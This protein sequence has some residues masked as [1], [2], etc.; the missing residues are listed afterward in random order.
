[1]SVKPITIKGDPVLRRHSTPVEAFGTPKLR[2][3]VED[4]RDT[5]KAADGV[6]IAAP[7]IGV[8][9][10]VIVVGFE[11]NGNRPERQPIPIQPIV[12][13]VYEVSDPTI[14]E[15]WEGC[16]SVPDVRGLIPRYRAIRCTG[17][18][19]EGNSLT[20]EA[21]GYHA[22][23]IQHECDHL[24]GKLFDDLV[25]AENLQTKSGMDAASDRCTEQ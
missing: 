13:P 16:L 7:Q 10:R 18:D 3:L 17:Y 11:D 20:F 1:M 22:R 12:N 14:E 4:L 15:D 9:L 23:I 6:G 19:V 24:D 21:T 2:Q 8:N 5:M 25:K